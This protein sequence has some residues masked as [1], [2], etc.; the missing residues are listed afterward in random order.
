M[1]SNRGSS[2]A[3]EGR[4][5]VELELMAAPA[6]L[7]TNRYF[8]AEGCKLRVGTYTASN[9]MCIYLESDAPAGGAPPAGPGACSGQGG[10]AEK[11]FWVKSRVAV[12]NARFPER[13][14]W[15]ESAICT[16]TWSNSVLQLAQVR[17][18]GPD[19]LHAWSLHPAAVL[20]VGMRFLPAQLRCV[21]AAAVADVAVV[22]LV[23]SW[24]S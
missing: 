15:K 21:C 10:A 19:A 2:F 20:P 17:C 23:R 1:C 13:T 8:S 14:T 11:N 3:V 16:K 4:A 6:P 22:L 18:S 5:A 7:P 9:V 24:T 12:L